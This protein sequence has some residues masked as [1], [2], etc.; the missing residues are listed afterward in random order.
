MKLKHILTFF[1]ALLLF[2]N[3]ACTPYKNIPYFQ[4]LSRDSITR[5]TISNYSPLTIQPGDQL[6]IHFTSLN[7]EASALF[8]YNLER[9]SGGGNLDR[10]EQN[11]VVGYYVDQNG[12]IT[13]PLV[14]NV[15]AQ[16]LTTDQLARTLE[17][18]TMPY[19]S[20]PTINVR[21]QNFKISVL[22][23]VRIPNTFTIVNERITIPEALSMAGDLNITG[24]RTIFL[25]R[26]A[27]GKREYVPIDLRSKKLFE[28]P[29]YYL[30]KNDILYIQPNEQRAANDGSTF[31]RA[32]LIVSVLSIV[33]ILLTR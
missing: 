23:D 20:K 2:F 10:S 11:A 21:I 30:K 1:T 24:V 12:N 32:G 3:F 15:K 19:L 14:G 18:K 8:N 22:G 27:D 4:D 16:G 25:I 29:Y 26:E 33:A 5:E 7:V 9:P 6:G 13:L 31:Q 28:S 17:T